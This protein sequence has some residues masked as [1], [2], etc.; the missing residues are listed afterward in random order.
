[1]SV[2]AADIER[3]RAAVCD[4]AR[5]TPVLESETLSQRCGARV[6]L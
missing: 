6:L 3:A 5:R 1:M 2:V 4:V